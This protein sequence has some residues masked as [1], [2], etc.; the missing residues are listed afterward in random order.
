MQSG[1]PLTATAT[2]SRQAGEVPRLRRIL[3]LW[4]AKLEGGLSLGMTKSQIC[5]FQSQGLE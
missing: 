3:S 4:V 1:Q 2:P 5:G